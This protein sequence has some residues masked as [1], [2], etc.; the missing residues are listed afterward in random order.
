MEAGA[1]AIEHE[2][3]MQLANRIA[4]IASG[5]D[6]LGGRLEQSVAARQVLL[7]RKCANTD[8][9]LTCAGLG[10]TRAC[11]RNK[12]RGTRNIAEIIDVAASFAAP[13]AL[14]PLISL[15]SCEPQFTW[16]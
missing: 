10:R 7:G 14:G 12:L 6:P 1:V 9:G 5:E 13:F 8:S 2:R 15:H 4:T 3:D 16:L 11:G